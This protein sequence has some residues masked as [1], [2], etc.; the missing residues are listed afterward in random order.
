MLRTAPLLSAIVVGGSGL[1][2]LTTPPRAACSVLTLDAVRAIVAAPVDVFP[3]GS[4]APTTRNGATFSNCTYVTGGAT[5]RGARVTLMWGT[6]AKL[7]ETNAYYVKR[8]KELSTIRGDVLV[9]ASV[10]DGSSAGL[11]YDRPASESLLAAVV[12]KLT[13]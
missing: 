9:L 1:L 7:S 5:S 10:T 13:P 6:S 3:A 11:T 12:R 8:N 2:S 4:S